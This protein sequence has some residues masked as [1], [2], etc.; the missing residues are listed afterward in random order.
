MLKSIRKMFPSHR[1]DEEI[2][3]LTALVIEAGKDFARSNVDFKRTGLYYD[4]RPIEISIC[5]EFSCFMLH[6]SSRVVS[7]NGKAGDIVHH[8]MGNKIADTFA[9]YFS[10][11]EYGTVKRRA[12]FRD[13]V[14]SRI[15]E[16]EKIYGNCKLITDPTSSNYPLGSTMFAAAQEICGVAGLDG[17]EAYFKIFAE[18]TKTMTSHNFMKIVKVISDNLRDVARES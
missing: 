13:R 6:F 2:D 10:E 7:N 12:S 11:L 8:R 15:N 4:D 9:E 14:T 5:L 18:I 17:P 3:F 16:T 1:A